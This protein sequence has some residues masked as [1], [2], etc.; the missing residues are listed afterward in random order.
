[1]QEGLSFLG[2]D[3]DPKVRE[4]FQRKFPQPAALLDLDCWHA[5]EIEN[6][7]TFRQMYV[8]SVRR[9]RN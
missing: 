8:F 2:F 7:L 6:P 5:F 9:L 1:V 3:G 4:R